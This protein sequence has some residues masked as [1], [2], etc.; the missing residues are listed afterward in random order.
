MAL[1]M[2]LEQYLA[3]RKVAYDVI[4]HRPTTSSSST[5]EASHVPG[6]WLAKAVI[7]KDGEEFMVAVLP[8]SHH[9]RIGELARLLDRPLDLFL[10]GGVPGG[11][12]GCRDLA[13]AL[14]VARRIKQ[15]EPRLALRGIEGFE[16]LIHAETPEAQE[17]Q[18]AAFLDFIVEI[19]VTCDREDLFTGDEVV[20]SAGGSAFYDMVVQRFAEAGLGR[21][22]Q[23]LTRSGCYLTHDSAIYRR[24]FA[25]LRERSPEVEAFTADTLD[26]IN[27]NV[28][29]FN[30][31]VDLAADLGV[32]LRRGVPVAVFFNPDGLLIGTTNEG[33]LEPARYYTSKQILKF[34]RDIVEKSSIA[35]PD[36][37]Q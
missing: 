13:T 35:A 25:R 9:L 16:G 1:A 6:D 10:E 5:A 22:V 29:K 2:T 3:D 21:K 36:S 18:V 8:A 30:I 31:N 4:T 19:A 17:A 14:Q 20:L 12:T 33:Q 37:V 34:V 32:D 15:A 28:G 27:V 23:V 26:F 11:R 7:V 24:L